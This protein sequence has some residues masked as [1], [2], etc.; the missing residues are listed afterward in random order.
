MEAGPGIEVASE[1]QA[2]IDLAL[3]AAEQAR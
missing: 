1:P 3:R 2:A